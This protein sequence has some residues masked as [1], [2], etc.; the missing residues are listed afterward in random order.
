MVSGLGI[1]KISEQLNTPF[2]DKTDRAYYRKYFPTYKTFGIGKFIHFFSI[3]NAALLPI[4][5]RE[6]ENL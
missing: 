4:K 5:H 1:F 6:R 3:E 2:G